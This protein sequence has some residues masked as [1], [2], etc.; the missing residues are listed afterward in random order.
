MLVEAAHITPLAFG[1]HG[2]LCQ[3]IKVCKSNAQTKFKTEDFP[4]EFDRLPEAPG[5][6]QEK[7]RACGWILLGSVCIFSLNHPVSKILHGNLAHAK[8]CSRFGVPGIPPLATLR[9][10]SALPEP[11]T[12][13][14]VESYTR[15]QI[16]A[17]LRR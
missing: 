7:W 16:G 12:R 14:Y 15:V 11:Q 5:S 8:L 13:K 17:R 10:A 2:A 4:Q 3:Q 9:V 1:E 6:Q